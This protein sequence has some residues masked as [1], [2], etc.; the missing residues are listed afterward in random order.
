MNKMNKNEQLKLML[1]NIRI[2]LNMEEEEFRDRL[3]DILSKDD[4]IEEDEEEIYGL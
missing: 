1:E 2:K 4:D 3:K